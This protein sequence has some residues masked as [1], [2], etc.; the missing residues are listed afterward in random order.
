MKA[1]LA[2]GKTCT[3]YYH[4]TNNGALLMCERPIND[5]L[6]D[7]MHV[8]LVHVWLLHHSRCIEIWKNTGGYKRDTKRRKESQSHSVRDRELQQPCGFHS[9]S[10][11]INC[12]RN[13]LACHSPRWFSCLRHRRCVALHAK[14]YREQVTT[15]RDKER[16]LDM[17]TAL[18]KP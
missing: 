8:F 10:R 14:I 3:C 13:K 6:G 11:K 16:T 15:R 12:C 4:N 7:K 1:N 2:I 5:S 18:Q 17:S 9:N